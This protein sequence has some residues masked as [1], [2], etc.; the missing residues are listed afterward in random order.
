[1]AIT[2]CGGDK[3]VHNREIITAGA[4]LAGKTLVTAAGTVPSSAAGGSFAVTPNDVASGDTFSGKNGIGSIIEVLATGTV[5]AGTQV[6]VLT[7]T[8]N[9]NINGTSTSVTA[10]GVSTIASGFPVGVAKTSGDSGSYVLIE[11]N[12]TAKGAVA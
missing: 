3:L 1:M 9:A 12:P 2:Y 6:E 5:T 10:A 11:W 7:T 4:N 8:I